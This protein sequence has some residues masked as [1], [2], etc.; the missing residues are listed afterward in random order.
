MYS[1]A[2]RVVRTLPGTTKNFRF[3]CQETVHKN[4]TTS[5]LWSNNRFNWLQ[6]N[7]PFFSFFSF[8][9]RLWMNSLLRKALPIS[10]RKRNENKQH[11][12]CCCCLWPS[13]CKTTHG[14]MIAKN[15]ERWFFCS[16]NLNSNLL[17]CSIWS[18]WLSRASLRRS[19]QDPPFHKQNWC[20]KKKEILQSIN[21][22]LENLTPQQQNENHKPAYSLYTESDKETL[23]LLS[24]SFDSSTKNPKTLRRIT[25]YPTHSFMWWIWKPKA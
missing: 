20:E 16:S 17:H 18:S 7:L 13:N 2:N 9:C 24:F 8:F 4:E 5:S 3:R 14:K 1:F 19:K 6:H 22:P 11:K 15:S 12:Y 21:Q 10:K 25:R 23:K